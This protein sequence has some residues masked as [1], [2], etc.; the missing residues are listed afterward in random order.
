MN[1][2][3]HRIRIP[4]YEEQVDLV[5]DALRKGE[6]V[7]GPRLE[8]LARA[9]SELF[10]KKQVVLTANGFSALFLA[11]KAAPPGSGSVRTVPLGTCFVVTHAI[12]AAGRRPAFSDVEFNSA[13]LGAG[14][15]EPDAD[16][17]LVPDHFGI[18][19]P[20][21]RKREPGW[22]L[23]I[24][25]AAQAFHS[26]VRKKSRADAVVLSFYPTK[27]ANGIDGG[28]ILTDDSEFAERCR[29]LCAYSDQ[30]GWE[31][32]VRYNLRMNNVNAAMALGTLA[33]L[34]E[35][36]ER[37]EAVFGI[38]AAALRKRGVAHLAPGAGEVASR[39]VVAADTEQERERWERHFRSLEIAT[40][41][42]LMFVCPAA[43]TGDHP[44]AQRLVD[45][46]FSLPFHPLLGE[47]EIDRMEKAICSL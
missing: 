19:A 26:R 38:L 3:I 45:T 18:L 15:P 41:R 32:E 21:C 14:G 30:R 10:G 33:H 4:C 37:L 36:A 11:L 12:R 24:E 5:R 35:E 16:V 43:A 23:F 46:T 31:E 13:S 40:S 9:L 2:P 8:M 34:D 20:A 1:D 17:A 42:E 29:R 44:V 6:L 25:D 28:A 39:L 7:H 47:P 22:N 27:W